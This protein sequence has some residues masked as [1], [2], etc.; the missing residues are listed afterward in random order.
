MKWE[1]LLKNMVKSAGVAGMKQ[2]EEAM[3]RLK[4]EVDEPWKRAIMDMLA[5][6]VEKY[7]WEGVD[8]VQEVVDRIAAGKVPDLSFASL[9]ARSNALAF[10]QNA[11]ADEKAKA[12]DFLK[13][14]GEVLSVI[15]K[16]VIKGLLKG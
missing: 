9:E 6:A 12:R 8:R 7:G 4:R 13:V 1:D 16:V 3:D 2:A 11:A 5:D 10:M 14:A 15:L